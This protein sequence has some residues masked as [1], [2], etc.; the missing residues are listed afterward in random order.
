MVFGKTNNYFSTA[1]IEE[2][3]KAIDLTNVLER[4]HFLILILLYET[5]AR[6]NE[7]INIRVEDVHL[8][9]NPQIDLKSL[10]T[11]RT[12]PLSVSITKDIEQYIAENRLVDNQRL[13]FHNKNICCTEL[14][15]HLRIYIKR[16][17]INNPK[18]IPDYDSI[19]GLRISRANHLYE[20]GYSIE[21]LHCF[22]GHVTINETKKFIEIFYQY[23]RPHFS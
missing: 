22:L 2:I 10:H 21:D 19:Y 3:F 14:C 13:F 5:A 6:V 17:R 23:S 20:A 18:L 9:N 11:T 15:R 1:A 8:D 12:V 4:Q 16:A 7:I